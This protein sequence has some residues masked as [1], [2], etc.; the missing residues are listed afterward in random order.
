MIKWLHHL[1]NPHCPECKEERESEKICRNCEQLTLQ[2][3]QI[4]YEKKQMLEAI[5]SFNRPPQVT[6][7]AA[8]PANVYE[9]AR[10]T[11]LPWHV[12]RQMLE[13]EDRKKAQILAEYKKQQETKVPETKVPETEVKA[14][15]SIEELEKE[16]EIG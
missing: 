5:L 11:A 4:N 7:P 6:E 14:G 12:R 16:L 2:I 3:D 13:A 9:N 10:K 8:I 1:L 15:Q